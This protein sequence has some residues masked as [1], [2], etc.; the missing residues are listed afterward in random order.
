MSDPQIKSERSRINSALLKQLW[1]FS[2]THKLNV[3]SASRAHAMNKQTN[4]RF[5]VHLNE[6]KE[7]EKEE[8]E[9]EVRNQQNYNE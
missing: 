5:A 1:R 2:S 6:E 7:G 4:T 3:A 9:E 8:E